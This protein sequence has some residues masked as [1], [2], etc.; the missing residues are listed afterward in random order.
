M[1]E[2]AWV[3]PKDLANNMYGKY[4]IDPE[5]FPA[6]LPH[7]TQDDKLNNRR[8]LY[9]KLEDPL[10]FICKVQQDFDEKLP[11][12]IWMF[13]TTQV[14][15]GETVRTSAER[16][17]FYH[18]GDLEYYTL[19]NA[20]ILYHPVRHS[21]ML[22]KEYPE[23]KQVKNFYMH[24]VY[25]GGNVELEPDGEIT[26][27]AWVTQGELAEYFENDHS[28]DVLKLSSSSLYYLHAE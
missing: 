18:A 22:K 24:S 6:A 13:P 20:P 23:A 4:G 7:V 19:G 21:N 25:L 15:E 28:K 9:R 16:T 3:L 14:R 17:L 5:E 12:E 26:D 11:K 2:K 27:Y 8:S 10:F 1:S